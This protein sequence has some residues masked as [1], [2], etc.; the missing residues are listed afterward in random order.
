MNFIV[1][2][3]QGMAD[4]RGARD[5]ADYIGQ[6]YSGRVVEVGAGYIVSVALHLRSFFPNIDLIITDREKRTVQGLVVEED[7]IFYPRPELY[8]GASLLYSL[9]P[10]LEM[11]LAMGELAARIGAEVLVRPLG[12]EVAK[13]PGFQRKLLNA[14]AA[15][16]YLF[17]PDRKLAEI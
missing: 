5:L 8:Q 6:N 2:Q 10:P 13:P 17:R 3:N 11:Q 9:R 7:D 15:R 16:F 12:D 4:L 1:F 14:G